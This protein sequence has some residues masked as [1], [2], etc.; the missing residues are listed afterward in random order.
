MPDVSFMPPLGQVS[1]RGDLAHPRLRAAV[2][3]LTGGPVPD[4]LRIE[5][6]SARGAAW[7]SPDELLLFL[8]RD[9]VGPALQR[10]TSELDG[11]HHLALDVSDLRMV[12]RIEGEGAREVLA[13]L[14]PA[15][16]HPDSFGPGHFRRTRLGQVAAGLWLEGK[17]ACIVCFRSVADYAFLLLRQSARDGG[18]GYF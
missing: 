6:T 3:A 9:E 12:L 10:L 13:K 8:P 7:M 1:L 11:T 4:R 16:L 5:G 15:D 18:V 17:G 14:C 2:E